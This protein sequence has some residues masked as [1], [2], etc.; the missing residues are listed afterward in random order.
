MLLPLMAMLFTDQVNWDLADFAIAGV[1]LFGAGLTYELIASRGGTVTYRAA[2]GLAVAAALMLVWMNLAV[3][4][5]GNEE[6]P[7]NLMYSGVLAVGVIGAIIARFRP[8]GMASALFATALAQAVV[9][10]IALIAGMHQLPGSSVTEIV[11]L[12]GFFV[13]LFAISASLFRRA[14]LAQA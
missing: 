2:V 6:H 4:I 3:G 9:A 10:A 5:L 14:P 8:R 1:L 13:A 7:A 12:N 11:N